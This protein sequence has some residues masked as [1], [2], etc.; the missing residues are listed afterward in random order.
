[1]AGLVALISPDALAGA[2]GDALS[3]KT[4]AEE[5]AR[6]TGPGDGD[7]ETWRQIFDPQRCSQCRG[8][9]SAAFIRW[10]D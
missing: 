2:A 5:P 10:A 1:M 8:R 4:P 9:S 6:I 3:F 7:R